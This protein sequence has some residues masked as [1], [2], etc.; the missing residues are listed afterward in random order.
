MVLNILRISLTCNKMLYF[1]NIKN[2]MNEID[3]RDVNSIVTK[4]FGY[5]DTG[6]RV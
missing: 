3:N 1:Y 2:Y 6:V 4:L 5:F